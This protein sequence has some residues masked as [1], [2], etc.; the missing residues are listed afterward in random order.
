[1]KKFFVLLLIVPVFSSFSKPANIP[2]PPPTAGAYLF[3]TGL[4]S[5]AGIAAE[6][7][8]DEVKLTSTAQGFGFTVS[9]GGVGLP[10]TNNIS[11]S[12][13]VVSKAFDRS[14]LR[15]QFYSLL[16]LANKDFEVRIYD[17]ISQTAVYKVVLKSVFVTTVSTAG[18]DC[19]SGSGCPG[20]IESLSFNPLK[21]EW[22]NLRTSPA[23]ILR[24]DVTMNSPEFVE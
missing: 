20:L 8:A 3:C 19:G 14:S 7:H 17:G 6:G 10:T 4:T 9:N 5:G 24:Y 11:L 22:H 13:L 16:K 2:A 23:Q 1:M 15:I 12:E 18:G 21:I